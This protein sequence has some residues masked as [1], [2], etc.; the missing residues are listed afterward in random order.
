MWSSSSMEHFRKTPSDP[1]PI[2][3]HAGCPCHVKRRASCRFPKSEVHFWGLL[4]SRS[5]TT[6]RKPS[7]PTPS[8]S[9][10]KAARDTHGH[11]PARDVD[12]G[13]GALHLSTDRLKVKKVSPGE[14][15]EWASHKSFCARGGSSLPIPFA[16]VWKGQGHHRQEPPPTPSSTNPEPTPTHQPTENRHVRFNPTH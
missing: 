1:R 7:P 4:R 13:L 11:T 16:Y 9:P 12:S 8:A 3:A 10:L 2:S 15:P 6:H 14:C 5:M